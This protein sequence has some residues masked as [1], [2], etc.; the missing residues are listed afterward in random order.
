MIS[1]PQQRLGGQRPR[2]RGD[3]RLGD[4]LLEAA[5]G[6]PQ[7]SGA[8][9]AA[10]GAGQGANAPLDVAQPH[11][12]GVQAAAEAA[13][14]SRQP[15]ST[16]PTPATPHV[17]ELAVM[18]A[19]A[20]P[21]PARPLERPAAVPPYRAFIKRRS[22][23]YKIPGYEPED[24]PA[25]YQERLAALVR[26]RGGGRRLGAVYLRA[27]CLEVLL[28]SEEWGVLESGP[29]TDGGGSSSSWVGPEAATAAAAAAAAAEGRQS[30][31]GRSMGQAG[32]GTGSLE[33]DELGSCSRNEIAALIW[34]LQAPEAE[35][36]DWGAAGD[37]RVAE[38]GAPRLGS[39][40]EGLA[41]GRGDVQQA[42]GSEAAGVA[43]QA[44]VEV[45]AASCGCSA[46]GQMERQP[47][48]GSIAAAPPRPIASL[49]DR[50]LPQPPVITVVMLEPRVLLLPPPP[51]R[52][53]CPASSRP[54]QPQP[55]PL[56]LPYHSPV[57]L[58]SE[59]QDQP[60]PSHQPPLP[61]PRAAAALHA[62]VSCTSCALP[63]GEGAA[64]SDAGLEVLVLSGGCYLPVRLG[65]QLQLQGYGYGAG[66][67]VASGTV[68]RQ[69]ADRP[70]LLTVE[71]LELPARPGIALVDFRWCGRPFC[72][73]PLLLTADPH[74]AAELGSVAASW[75]YSPSELDSLLL[76]YG[77]WE[78]HTSAASPASARPPPAPTNLARSLD[79]DGGGSSCGDGV[80]DTPAAL[81]A[82]ASREAIVAASL[83]TLG[84]HLLRCAEAAGWRHTA[85]RL[86]ATSQTTADPA[87]ARSMAPVAAAV[88]SGAA[89][90]MGGT[91]RPPPGL[92]LA[93]AAARALPQRYGNSIGSRAAEA[94]A[95]PTDWLLALSFALGLRRGPPADEAAYRKFTEPWALAHAH[96]MWVQL[97]WGQGS[98]GGGGGLGC[99]AGAA[100]S[101][102][103]TGR[104][105]F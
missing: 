93:L 4:Q 65:W 28:E 10:A 31:V 50:H 3:E 55:Q 99:G 83:V 57:N 12:L 15:T 80:A 87:A 51:A 11:A 78:C 49:M 20:V 26:A 77:T 9:P 68:A 1:Q 52:V 38:S 58:V 45:E 25:G 41:G 30:V 89:P 59:Q 46:A 34:A 23:L 105:P 16:P 67:S 40:L 54:P 21:A 96:S 29:Q 64:Q 19:E 53:R 86:Q 104:L 79:G 13:P 44:E 66:G 43:L 24:V 61:P 88:D 32:L 18:L 27:G 47:S 103:Q 62:V 35:E 2:G 17:L 7:A 8:A 14:A 102:R 71:L 42:S 75:P 81:A 39:T 22:L 60:Q 76:D 56:H 101:P 84:R 91:V 98:A 48:S 90:I 85:A 97:C 72:V 82:T 63:Y 5:S 33:E 94:A 74:V 73:V 36:E 95:A 70:Q 100:V 92:R 6:G 37:G 69:D